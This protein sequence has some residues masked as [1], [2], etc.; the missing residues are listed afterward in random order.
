MDHPELIVCGF[1][2]NSIGPQGLN[3]NLTCKFERLTPIY[4]P[5]IVSRHPPRTGYG[6]LMNTAVNL[7]NIANNRYI[8]AIAINT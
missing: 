8:I 7:D 2:E 4:T 1:M 3:C 6:I 5:I